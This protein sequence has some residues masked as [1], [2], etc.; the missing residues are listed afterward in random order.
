MLFERIRRGQK[1]VFI[2]LA[3]MFGLGFVALGV[4]SGA[5]GINL[6]DI[7]NTSSVA[8]SSMSDGSAK[9]TWIATVSAPR[10]SRNSSRCIVSRADSSRCVAMGSPRSRASPTSIR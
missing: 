5:G 7:L 4:G 6:G 1:P 10:T 9:T 2:F 8:I 3:V